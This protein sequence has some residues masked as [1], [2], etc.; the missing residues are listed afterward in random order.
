MYTRA[1]A[2]LMNSRSASEG[3]PSILM[4]SLSWSM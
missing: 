3:E 4:I 1:L 2:L